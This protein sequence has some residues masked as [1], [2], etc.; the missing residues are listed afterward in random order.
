MVMMVVIVLVKTLIIG[1]S[2]V[3]NL[4]NHNFGCVFLDAR[5]CFRNIAKVVPNKC[6]SCGAS[7]CYVLGPSQVQANCL[8]C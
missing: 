1:L 8:R 6:I 2:S 4:A 7:K 3:S 5:K